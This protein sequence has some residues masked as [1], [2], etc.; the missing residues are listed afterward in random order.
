MAITEILP[1][2]CVCKIISFTTPKDA[3]RS[4][5]VSSAFKEC[6]DSDETW[7]AFLPSDCRDLISRSSSPNLISLPTKQLYLHLS[8]HPLLL[9]DKTMIFSLVK[10]SGKKCYVIGGKGLCVIWGDT[11]LYWNWIC[12]PHSRFPLVAELDHVWWFEV[13]GSLNIKLLSPKTQYD[14]FF[15]FSYA[16]YSDGFTEAPVN[17]SISKAGEVRSLEVVIDVRELDVKP[18]EDL[19]LEVKAGEFFTEEEEGEGL[20]EFRA[21][22]TDAH[23][24]E[25]IT[26]E[27]IEFRPTM[28]E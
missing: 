11:P 19:W 7:E 3:C 15:V 28:N 6:A 14:V 4:S 12:D 2:E 10:E 8:D 22:Q 1:R 21:W 9:A 20:V 24:K 18:R 27:G 13:K 23:I 25:G 5:A 16:D 26:I 17:F